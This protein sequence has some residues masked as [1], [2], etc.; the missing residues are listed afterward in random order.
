MDTL[1]QLKIRPLYVRL[2]MLL[3]MLT[4]QGCQTNSEQRHAKSSGSPPPQHSFPGSL[5]HQIDIKVVEARPTVETVYDE[6]FPDGY[7]Y[8]TFGAAKQLENFAIEIGGHLVLR[9]A[10]PGY[11]N[12][13]FEGGTTGDGLLFSVKMKHWY[14][15]FPLKAFSNPSNVVLVEG[16]CEVDLSISKG[17]L[18]LFENAYYT[19]GNKQFAALDGV[20]K[21]EIPRFIDKNLDLKGNQVLGYIVEEILT[22]LERQWPA[23][24]A[25]E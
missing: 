23:I 9:A 1:T 3:L 4:G 14:S 2:F 11:R 22:D 15:R 16:R 17:D 25:A 19:E 13:N 5:K 24:L 21:P 12:V 10:I 6:K 7:A 20:T 18:L 8:S